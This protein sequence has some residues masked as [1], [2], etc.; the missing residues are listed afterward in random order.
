MR[1]HA[2]IIWRAHTVSYAAQ[3]NPISVD[4]LSNI[5]TKGTGN[6]TG[7]QASNIT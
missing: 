5:R 4:K 3:L 2:I 7:H 1:N 6:N